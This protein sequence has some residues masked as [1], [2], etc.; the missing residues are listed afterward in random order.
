VDSC[1]LQIFIMI[2][3]LINKYKAF[4]KKKQLSQYSSYSGEYAF[5]GVGNHSLSNLYPVIDYLGVPLKY[6]YSRTLENAQLTAAKY[7]A[8]ATDDLQTILNDKEIKGVFVCAHPETH[9][10]LAKQILSAGKALFIEKPPCKTSEELEELIK[11]SSDKTVQVGLQKRYASVYAEIKKQMKKPQ[12]YKLNFQTGAYPE[13]NALWD[14]FIHPLDL[15]I[16]LFG[17]VKTSTIKQSPN[18]ETTF[19]LLEHESGVVGSLELSTDYSWAA[20]QES[21]TVNTKSGIF[22]SNGLFNLI[23]TEKSKKIAGIPLEKVIQKPVKQH[24]LLSNNG[25]VP[26]AENNSLT[27]QGYYDE[28]NQF[29][30]AVEGVKSELTDFPELLKS[31]QL[32]DQL[33]D[34][35]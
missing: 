11:I 20:P 34:R 23:F 12:S 14:L 29:V 10:S 18:T 1:P 32:L 7:K 15:S 24:V 27:L 22:E 31:Y 16:F 33:G 26:I 5:V 8:Q 3:T 35:F 6:I 21:L 13:G 17:E 28:I 25:F 19:V 4:R 9:F 30:T 2:A